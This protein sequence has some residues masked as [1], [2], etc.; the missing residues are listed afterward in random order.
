M[1]KRFRQWWVRRR[2]RDEHADV[3][4]V[5]EVERGSDLIGQVSFDVPFSVGIVGDW[6]ERYRHGWAGDG[7]RHQRQPDDEREHRGAPCR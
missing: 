3:F 1:L 4:P 5:S 2:E 7:P 6:R